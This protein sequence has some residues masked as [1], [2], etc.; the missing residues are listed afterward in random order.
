M[1]EKEIYDLSENIRVLWKIIAIKLSTEN[2][3][4]IQ[5]EIIIKVC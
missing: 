2:N 1:S 4:L 5:L 3:T